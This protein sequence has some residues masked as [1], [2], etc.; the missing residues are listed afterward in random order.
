MLCSKKRR[1]L[2]FAPASRPE[3]A[4]RAPSGRLSGIDLRELAAGIAA[5][6]LAAGAAALIALS[7][8]PGDGNKDWRSSVEEY[9][10]L[11]T[12]ETFSPLQPDAP[13]E[14][15]GRGT[16]AYRVNRECW[17]EAPSVRRKEEDMR[18]KLVATLL[19]A[20]ALSD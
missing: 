8:A 5:C 6:V 18:W 19:V 4:R 7:L 17:F 14:A 1:F 16:S 3:D 10:S 9:T 20:M 15:I 12:N 2:N 11:Y 13:L